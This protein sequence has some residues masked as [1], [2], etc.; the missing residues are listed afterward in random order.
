MRSRKPF[1]QKRI[2]KPAI[3]PSERKKQALRSAI[4]D[5]S[6]APRGAERLTDGHFASTR[7]GARQ[8]KIRH[9]DAA[10]QQHQPHGAKQQNQRLTDVAD[11]AFLQRHQTHAAIPLATG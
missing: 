6:R 1:V 9:V 8:Q 2:A 5:I 10:N 7:A 11:H 3:P 4:A